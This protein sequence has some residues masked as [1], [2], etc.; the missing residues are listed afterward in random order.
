[1]S[2]PHSRIVLMLA[3]A[4][5]FSSAVSAFVLLSPARHWPEP[6]KTFVLN[7]GHVSIADSDNGLTAVR[8]ALTNNSIGWNSCSN[9]FTVN[10]TINTSQSW[11]LGDGIPTVS[12]RREIGGCNGSCLAAT[13]TGYYSCPGGFDG[14]DGHCRI[15]DSDVEGRRNRAD[16]NGGPY[17]TTAEGACTAGAEYHAESIWVHEAG[18]Q[19]GLGHSGV[20]GATMF[21]SVSS[22]NTSLQSV[23]T[24]DCN[25]ANALYN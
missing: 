14:G 22:C 1:M 25:G 20:S 17:Y 3:V 15:D 16:N 12:L 13:Y 21:P 7:H 9:S 24:D 5:I 2:R 23:A 8:N 6:S 4:L 19:L 10:A 18:H 11:V